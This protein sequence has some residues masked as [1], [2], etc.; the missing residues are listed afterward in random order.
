[1]RFLKINTLKEYSIF[2]WMILISILGV[3]V[4]S[5]YSKNKQEQLEMIIGSLDNIY[6]KKTIQEITK[7]L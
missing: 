7:T 4:F 6:L 3:I 1:M 5:I 2:F